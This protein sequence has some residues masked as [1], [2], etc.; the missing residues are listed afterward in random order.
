[1]DNRSEC[2]CHLGHNSGPSSFAIRRA[3]IIPWSWWFVFHS[4]YTAKSDPDETCFEALLVAAVCADAS[5]A[6]AAAVGAADNG[7]SAQ[8]DAH[9]DECSRCIVLTGLFGG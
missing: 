4:M 8:R 5:A 7:R 6:A 3:L 9:M 1:M 2:G